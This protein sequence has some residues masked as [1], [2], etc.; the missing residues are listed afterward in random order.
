MLKITFL[1][2]FPEAFDSFLTNSIIKRAI[3]KEVVEFK[4]INIRDFTLDK[5]HRVDDRPVGGGAGLIMKMQPVVDSLRFASSS[6]SKKILL[7]PHGQTFTQEKAKELSKEEDIVLICGH[8]EGIDSRIDNYIDEKISL[9]DFILTGGELASQVIA[10]SITRLLD[11]AITSES[12][13]EES[14][15]DGLLEYPQ[16]TLPYD[17]EG[18]K[19]PQILFSGNHE[20][21]KRYRKR[22]QFKLTRTYRKDLFDKYKFTKQELKILK[23]LDN[24]EHSKLELRALE[25]GKRFLKED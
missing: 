4:V 13:E 16:Y 6:K 22:E 1:T 21:I 10:D 14:F 25:K 18:Y 11:G 20:A 19:I 2:L 3:S 8:Y 17:Y 12:T 7:S 5:H 24:N 9:G 23:E 15:N